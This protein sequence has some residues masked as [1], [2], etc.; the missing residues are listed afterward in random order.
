MRF[1]V[2]VEVDYDVDGANAA[3]EIVEACLVTDRFGQA[4]IGEDIDI[5]ALEALGDPGPLHSLTR[6]LYAGS[7]A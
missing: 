6:P 2:L 1:L 3:R 7:V 4:M 5:I